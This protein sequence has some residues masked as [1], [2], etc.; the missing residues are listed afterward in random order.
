MEKLKCPKCGNKWEYKGSK[1]IYAPCSDCK[2]SVKI[3]EN[4]IPR[5]E[6]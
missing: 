1:K 2:Y 3:K 4:K 6:K 5:G